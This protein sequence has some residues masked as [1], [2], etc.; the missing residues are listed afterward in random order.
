ML[1][2][3]LTLTVPLSTTDFN[4]GGNPAMDLHPMEGEGGGEEDK[5]S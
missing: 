1:C 4:T 3:A 2:C 5:Y